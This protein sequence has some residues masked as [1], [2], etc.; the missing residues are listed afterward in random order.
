MRNPKHADQV[1]FETLEIFSRAVAVNRWI[2]DTICGKLQGKILEI[3]SGIGN[4]SEYLL[5]YQSEVALSD[6][7]PEYLQILEQKFSGHPHLRGIHQLDLSLPDFSIRYADLLGKF[8]TVLALNV[9][10]HIAD[11]RAAIGHAQS[12][13]RN[14]G[15]LVILVPAHP[16]LYNS[17]DRELGHFRRYTPAGLKKLM[18]STGLQFTGCRYFNAAAI[19]GWWYSGNLLHHKTISPSKLL[20]FNQMV[21]IFRILDRVCSSFT[22]ISLISAGIK[23]LN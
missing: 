4:I 8:D 2:Y 5:A 9:V 12:L 17:L 22:G 18:V 20:W 10:E 19:A 1:G 21:P 23:D 3:G 11:D 14:N 6:L 15:K 16:A 7:R 13:L